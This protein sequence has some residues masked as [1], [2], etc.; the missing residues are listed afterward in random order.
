MIG[1]GINCKKLIGCV[2]GGGGC[3]TIGWEINQ[4]MVGKL[5]RGGRGGEL[6]RHCWTVKDFLSLFIRLVS[7]GIL[8][9]LSTPT[10]M[11]IAREREKSGKSARG[12]MCF[13]LKDWGG[14]RC[15]SVSGGGRPSCG[16]GSLRVEEN[17][18][19]LPSLVLY[20]SILSAMWLMQPRRNSIYFIMPSFTQ[21]KKKKNPPQRPVRRRLDS[22]CQK[23]AA[24]PSS[25]D[26]LPRP[27]S[28]FTAAASNTYPLTQS[29]L[30]CSP[31][32]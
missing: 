19:P 31:H 12:F 29:P 28:F 24:C 9:S 22:L 1:N 20:V 17:P 27:A 4:D 16:S 13:T 21:R 18:S 10:E 15:V 26:E 6:T 32:R 25:V 8:S 14:G 30:S 11:R 7:I 5:K 23:A 2:C 3:Q